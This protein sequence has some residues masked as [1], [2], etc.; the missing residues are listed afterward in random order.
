MDQCS[1]RAMSENSWRKEN[2]VTSQ[3]LLSGIGLRTP[4]ISEFLE[5]KPGVAWVEVHTENYFGEGGR[6]I[7]M[8]EKVDA[9]FRAKGHALIEAAPDS[10]K[11]A[12]KRYLLENGEYDDTK[13]DV[14]KKEVLAY[15][16]ANFAENPLQ[17]VTLRRYV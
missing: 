1:N 6:P 4:H 12:F 2:I 8:L 11:E 13:E 9:Q 14:F 5:K 16:G 10:V 7:H 17:L 15:V 3:L